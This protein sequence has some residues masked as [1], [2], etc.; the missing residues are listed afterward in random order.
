MKA[1][2]VEGN[3]DYIVI[4]SLFPSLEGQGIMVR[5]AQ[6]S[7]N[8]FAVAKALNDYGYKVMVVLDTDSDKPGFDK[9]PFIQNR[10]D[11]GLTGR[12]IEVVWMDPYIE[13]VLGRV[14]PDLK[15]GKNKR[16][17]SFD[18]LLERYKDGI[19]GL[20]EFKKLK[21]FIENG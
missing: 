7:S 16:I 13:K 19:L 4:K 15:N 10:W 1:I 3:T 18:Y 12:D 11:I 21:E 2:V 6:G 8:V 14:V 5:I 17:R 20:V 9:R